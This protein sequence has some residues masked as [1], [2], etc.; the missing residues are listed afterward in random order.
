MIEIWKA[1]IKS[2]IPGHVWP[3]ADSDI[4]KHFYDSPQTRFFFYYYFSLD[5]TTIRDPLVAFQTTSKQIGIHPGLNR[6]IGA[7][8]KNKPIWLDSLIYIDSPKIFNPS[9]EWIE[10]ID[11]FSS[12][13]SAREISDHDSK[14]RFNKFTLTEEK[15]F[16]QILID[17]SQNAR[18]EIIDEFG[19]MLV[20]NKTGIWTLTKHI[21]QHG[22][23]Y[24]TLKSIYDHIKILKKQSEE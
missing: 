7:S 2:E 5:T 24:S 13:N 14:S 15:E 12:K 19:K 21:D 1:K 9:V 22:G 11:R 18:I 10:M 23:L 17:H 20:L 16:K 6:F 8:F 4:R 3:H